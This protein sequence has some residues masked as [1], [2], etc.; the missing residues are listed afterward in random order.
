MSVSSSIHSKMT[1]EKKARLRE[2]PR[3]IANENNPEKMKTLALENTVPPR[4]GGRGARSW[5]PGRLVLLDAEMR[6]EVFEA[7]R[8]F[9]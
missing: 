4:R 3:L 7:Y 6:D 5:T 2:L 1:P 8:M 9:E